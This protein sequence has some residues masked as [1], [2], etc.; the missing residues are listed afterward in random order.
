MA[1]KQKNWNLLKMLSNFNSENFAVEY[2][3]KHNLLG[4][5]K[6]IEKKSITNEDVEK[7]LLLKPDYCDLA[8]LHWLATQRRAINILELGGGFSSLIFADALQKNLNSLEIELQSVSR[9]SKPFVLFSVDES[10]ACV[11]HTRALIPE[12][13]REHS[14]ISSSKVLVKEHLGRICTVYEKLPNMLPDLIYIDG[15]SQFA[16]DGNIRG[17]TFTLPE[18]MPLSGDIFLIEYLLE[19]GCLIVCDGR[20]N[21]YQFLKKFL[22]R[23]WVGKRDFKADIG[24]LE[25]Q[26]EPLGNLNANKLNYSLPNGLWLES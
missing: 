3:K 4:L 6:S 26:E 11:K 18:R 20:T 22:S 2:L 9:A 15:P 5:L 19:P 16:C 7:G 24:L 17:V 8:R 14:N 10:E 23:N 21:N 1:Q 12:N 13:I 25:L